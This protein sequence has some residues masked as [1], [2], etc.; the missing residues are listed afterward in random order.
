MAS[1]TIEF[2]VKCSNELTGTVLLR[3]ISG[4]RFEGTMKL[5]NGESQNI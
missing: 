4:R 3:R 2:P 1:T 5:S